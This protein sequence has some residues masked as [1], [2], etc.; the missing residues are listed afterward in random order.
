MQTD[1]IVLR[2]R[3]PGEAIELGLH[4]TRGNW[5]AQI[6]LASTLLIPIA[7]IG[8]AFSRWFPPALL[9]TLIWFKPT[10]DRALLHQLSNDLLG[11]PAGWMTVLQEWRRWWRGGHLVTLLWQRFNPA[12]S[13]IL[14][15]WQLERLSGAARNRRVRVL[16]HND[17]GAGTSLSFLASLIELAFLASIIAL[18]WTLAPEQW[19]GGMAFFDW[20]MVSASGEQ[21]WLLIALA[22]L[23]VIALV[24]P[25]YV[26]AGFGIYLNQRSRLEGWDLEPRLKAMVEHHRPRRLSP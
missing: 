9:L 13:A 7:L 12:R 25:F 16:S 21:L 22:Y 5:P 23:P 20:L 4:L 26:G 24:E 3:S 8:L 1:R 11:R 14:P 17:R 6:A 15:V 10:L 19:T 2:P 18:A